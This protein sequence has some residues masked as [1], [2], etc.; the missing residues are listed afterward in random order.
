[1][2]EK[3]SEPYKPAAL[4]MHIAKSYFCA[5]GDFP[6]FAASREDLLPFFGKET[7]RSNVAHVL[8]PEK[9]LGQPAILR[10]YHALSDART[11]IKHLKTVVTDL[12]KKPT[13]SNWVDDRS[14]G[15]GLMCTTRKS[16]AA[17]RLELD[18]SG[19]RN[20]I[21]VVTDV[22][23]DATTLAEVI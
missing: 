23:P 12:H 20:D 15:I 10:M 22:G 21:L 7:P 5:L 2:S 1:M 3:R 6:R 14:Y 19:L 8:A 16:L 4:S 18:T 9:E 17:M 13:I 11:S